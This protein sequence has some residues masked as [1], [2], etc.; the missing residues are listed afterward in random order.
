MSVNLL[1]ITH[2]RVGQALLDTAADMLSTLSLTVELLPVSQSDVPEERL[3]QAQRL[4]AE[5]DTGDGVLVFTDA[6][7]STPS[8]IAA[9]LAV[10]HGGQA[11]IRVVA[12]LNLPMLLRAFNYPTLDLAAL[13][14]KVLEGG[15][16][17]ILEH[18][19]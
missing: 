14:A 1:L 8:N 18:K 3:Q 11:R 16:M 2:N 7:G 6:Y 15:R 10:Q 13:T 5:L 12:G 9:R 17:G 4:C 19:S